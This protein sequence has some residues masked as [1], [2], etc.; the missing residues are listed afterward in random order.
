MDATTRDAHTTLM[1]L[2]KNATLLILF[3]LDSHRASAPCF[4]HRLLSAAAPS[5][6]AGEAVTAASASSLV[7]RYA[8]L[9]SRTCNIFQVPLFK[10]ERD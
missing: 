10:G 7:S 5:A 1:C 8:Q 3:E 2:K 4:S 9:R 6:R